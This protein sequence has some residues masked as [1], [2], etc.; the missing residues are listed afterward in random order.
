MRLIGHER[1]RGGRRGTLRRRWHSLRGW[2]RL[3]RLIGSLRGR[4]GRS[5]IPW[6]LLLRGGCCLLSRCGVAPLLLLWRSVAAASSSA[7]LGTIAPRKELHILTVN[8]QA[9]T[10]LACRPIIPLVH[11][12]PAFH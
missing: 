11:F 10:L 2:L 7:L 8:R 4:R 9:R 6:P 5:P 12:Q 1:R 3:W